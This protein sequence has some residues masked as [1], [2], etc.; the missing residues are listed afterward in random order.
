MIE[1]N[2]YNSTVCR[3]SDSELIMRAL[4]LTESCTDLRAVA[5]Y[6][7]IRPSKYDLSNFESE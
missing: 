4:D 7:K 2:V 6:S 3:E 1:E 5:T